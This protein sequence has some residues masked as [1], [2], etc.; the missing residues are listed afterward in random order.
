MNHIRPIAIYLP[1][2]HAIPENDAA[3]GEGFTEWTN[4]KKAEPM[5]EGHYQPHE[6]HDDIGYYDLIDPEVLVRQAGMA[7]EY[8][9]YGFA[10]YHYWFN[11]KQLLEKP[12]ENMLK[13]GKPDFPFCFIW[14]NENWT[15]KWDG[16]DKSII[17]KQEYST[18]DDLAHIKFLCKNVFSDNRY[19]TINNKPVFIVYRTELFPDIKQTVKI[20]REEVTKH[21]F[22][23]I[24]LIRVESFSAGFNPV[25]I[26][27]DAALEFAPDHKTIFKDNIVTSTARVADYNCTVM[28][29]L[30]EKMSY[31]CIRSVFASWDNTPRA[32]G[33]ILYNNTHPL[34]FEYFLKETIDYTNKNFAKEERLIFL[35]AWN[36]WGEGCHLEPD[37]KNEYK[38]LETCRKLFI[39]IT[40]NSLEEEKYL[41]FLKEVIIHLLNERKQLLFESQN[42]LQIK[43]REIY[44]SN[45][46]KI[47]YLILLPLRYFKHLLKKILSK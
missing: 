4:V 43:T 9:I 13:S 12:L 37:K 22:N 29:M 35:N 26:G 36:E 33:G 39:D 21:G 11:G 10:Y 47:G 42:N 24:Y 30:S 3:W 32:K 15:R 7:E 20:W 34:A 19:I 44:N 41:P 25:D 38:F 14:A 28:S 8:G 2:F 17:I 1:Q 27:F 18:E 6:P 5:F 23:G 45:S 40:D 31:K 16:G 46:Y